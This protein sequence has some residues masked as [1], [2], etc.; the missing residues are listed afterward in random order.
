LG[1]SNALAWTILTAARA[2][3]TLGA[4]HS[5]IIGDTWTIPGERMKEGIAHSVPLAPEARAL[6][7][8]GSGPLFVGPRGKLGSHR[9]IELL[10]E[11]AP[12]F[13]VHGFRSTFSD[14]AAEN[15]FPFELREMALAHAVGGET[16]KAYNRTDLIKRRRD[17][18][19]SWAKYA[20][21]MECSQ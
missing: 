13:T 2:G 17:M 11:L 4:T 12:G 7:G 18:M 21:Q 19:E 3:E 1:A 20:C 8:S 15:R 16:Q 14:W 5:E 6:I 9:M 10:K